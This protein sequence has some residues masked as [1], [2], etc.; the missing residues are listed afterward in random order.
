MAAI[1]TGEI[2]IDAYIPEPSFR[3]FERVTLVVPDHKSFL[4]NV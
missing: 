3:A 4:K 1:G 2:R